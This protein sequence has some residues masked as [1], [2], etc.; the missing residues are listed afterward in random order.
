MRYLIFVCCVLFSLSVTAQSKEKK[1]PN[2]LMIAVDDL[3]DFIGALGNPDAITPNIDKLAAKGVVFTNAHCQAPLCGPSRASIMTGLRP[4]STGIYGMIADNDIKNVNQLKQKTPLLHQYFKDGGYHILGVGKI[5][6]QYFPDGLLDEEGGKSEYGPFPEK[7]FKWDKKGTATDWG[8][9]P[10]KDTEMPDDQA[11]EWAVK[12]LSQQYEKPFFLSVGLIRPHVPWYVPQKWFDL[13]DPQK[14]HLPAY[15]PNDKADLPGITKKIDDWPMMP[16][17][18][19]AIKN[20]EWRNILQAYLACV[21][22]TDYNIGRILKA[23]EKSEYADNTIIALWSDHGYRLGEK[24]T[25]AKVA[26]WDR[27]TKAPLIF[28]G[29]GIPEGK[30]LDQPVELLNIYPTL[31]ELAGL[32]ANRLNEGASLV[33]LMTK[34]N[35]NWTKPAITTWGRNNHSIKTN[36]Y[37]LIRYEDG[38]LELY[39]VQRDPNEWENLAAREDYQKVIKQLQNHLPKQNVAWSDKSF[40]NANEYFRNKGLK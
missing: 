31:T 14:L 11:T 21:S 18:E 16:T 10:E 12:K 34:E 39:D 29:A 40:Y 35:Y 19:W 22:Y 28:S 9:F 32:K 8:A 23:L 38:S 26:L 27:A 25:F 2:V 17:T 36:N 5:Y 20:N 33:P 24:N 30:K 3:N 13:Y 4:S 37:R 6:H 7:R 1:R 15:L